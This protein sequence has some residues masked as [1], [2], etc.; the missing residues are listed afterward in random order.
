M[1]KRTHVAY[2][3]LMP[4]IDGIALPR[5]QTYSVNGNIPITDVQE[6]ANAGVVEKKRGVPTVTLSL[7]TVDLSTDT[8]SVLANRYASRYGS[9][10]FLGGSSGSGYNDPDHEGVGNANIRVGSFATSDFDKDSNGKP[11]ASEILIPMRAE[12]STGID[13]TRHISYAFLTNINTTLS[14]GNNIAS[15]SFDMAAARDIVYVG[16]GTKYAACTRGTGGGS[17][18]FTTDVSLADVTGT[19]GYSSGFKI[20]HNRFEYKSS[21]AAHYGSDGSYT[22]TWS[23]NTVTVTGPTNPTFNSDDYIRLIYNNPNLAFQQYDS[24]VFTQ[25]PGGF[26]GR[27]VEIFVDLEV[28][29]AN[30][31]SL[32]RGQSFAYT[33]PITRDALDELGDSIPYYQSMKFP[34]A[35]TCDIEVLASDLEAW[36][37]LNGVEISYDAGNTPE[38][39]LEGMNRNMRLIAKIYT[40]PVTHDSTTL[41]RTVTIQNARISSEGETVGV[42][43]NATRTYSFVADNI[44]FAGNGV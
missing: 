21:N 14:V 19:A 22:I 13:A 2:S 4:I 25:F 17:N 28:S 41:W 6:L 38:V 23:G 15:E 5:F 20:L 8:L 29:G 7:A 33:V 12:G 18:T 36:A 42:G 44:Q 39:S 16:N 27:D 26:D 35:V 11:I 40:D 10:P 9:R 3:E 32:L 31:T 37:R 34:V 43:D 30:A 24:T 1:S